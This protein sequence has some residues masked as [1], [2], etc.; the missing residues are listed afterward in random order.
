MARIRITKQEKQALAEKGLK[1][2]G[3]CR[4]NKPFA[5]FASDKQKKDG[6]NSYCRSCQRERNQS[7]AGK[8]S[9]KKYRGTERGREATDRYRTSDTF[10]ATHK[11]WRASEA[12]KTA[13]RRGWER[14]SMTEK[15]RVNSLKQSAK[16]RARKLKAPS[17]DW[18][19]AQIHS[20]ANGRCLYCGIKVTLNE[21]HADHFIPLAKG[22]SNLR[23][24]IVC[25]CASCNLKKSDRMPEDFIGETL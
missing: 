24:N 22:G 1:R 20:E 4:E 19:H 15:G 14:Y 13:V 21:M 11:K 5:D 10:K 2:C 7:S 9:R 6:L 3:T 16:R 18:T 23:E 25:S 8:A 17:D 12:G